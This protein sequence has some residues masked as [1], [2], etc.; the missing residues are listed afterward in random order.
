MRLEH[1]ESEG[2]EGI[3]DSSLALDWLDWDW[4]FYNLASFD[5]FERFGINLNHF[6]SFSLKKSD[7]PFRLA[8]FYDSISFTGSISTKKTF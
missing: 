3:S 6:K 5:D 8:I 1:R 2:C 4:A 7:T